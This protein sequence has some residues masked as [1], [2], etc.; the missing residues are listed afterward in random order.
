LEDVFDNVSPEAWNLKRNL[1]TS[2][3]SIQSDQTVYCTLW[4]MDK[5]LNT[6]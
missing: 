1:F 3:E 4:K 5:N 6:L 2:E